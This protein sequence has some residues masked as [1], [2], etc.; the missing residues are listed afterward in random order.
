M[1]KENNTVETVETKEVKT[2]D[3][4]TQTLINNEVAKALKNIKGNLDNAYA[5]RDTY[6]SQISSIQ[7]DKQALEIANLEKAGKHQQV[8]EIKMAEMNSKLET[9]E[10]RNTELSRDNAVRSHLNALDF[11][12]DKAAKLAYSDIVDT[13]K[14][15]VDGNW[16]HENGSDIKTA[17]QNYVKDDSNAFMFNVKAN[18]GTGTN[19]AKPASGAQSVKSITDMSQAELLESISK[20]TTDVKGNWQT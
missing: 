17:V 16:V 4:A 20:G 12:N 11:R 8:M 15:D 10:K 1:E 5:E 9:Y 7:A 13:L 19:V 6:K 14:K 2:I 18:A 3:S